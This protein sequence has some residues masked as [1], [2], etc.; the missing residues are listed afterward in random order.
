[1]LPLKPECACKGAQLLSHVRLFATPWTVDHQAPLFVEFSR[2]EY[3]SGFPFP[4]PGDL[5]NPGTEP[6][7]PT[8]AALAGR[9]FTTQPP[10]KPVSES[11]LL[12]YVAQMTKEV[13]ENMNVAKRIG[14]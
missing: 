14:L 10:G 12:F 4:T 11:C 13:K 1:M 3:W 9:L 6:A 7:S 8:S 2:Q 5:P